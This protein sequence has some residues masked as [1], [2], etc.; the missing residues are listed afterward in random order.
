MGVPCACGIAASPPAG[1]HVR[2][3]HG[4]DARAAGRLCVCR[5]RRAGAPLGSVGA[6]GGGVIR[7]A[8][9]CRP[10]RRP[11]GGLS[12]R[13]PGA[14]ARGRPRPAPAGAMTASVLV[15]RPTA[16]APRQAMVSS[17]AHH[18]V[19]WA[20]YLFVCSIPF[21]FSDRDARDFPIEIPTALGI[22]FLA[23]T[24]L[25]PRTS[26]GRPSRPARWY[27]IY[28]YMFAV[29]AAI[30][31]R[32][33]LASILNGADY[34]TEALKML[35]SLVELFLIFWVARNLMRSPTV[36]RRALPAPGLAGAVRAAR[37]SLAI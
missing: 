31:G 18:V 4:R 35:F 19:C 17:L 11:A 7:V 15:A 30:S 21:E 25:Q 9:R 14:G 8:A 22:L 10:R 27:L 5:S 20:F 36:T 32:D 37:P 26:F 24:I 29:A 3:S 1:R 16:S 12:A 6:G 23:T 2:A 13:R 34:W 33:H 28:L